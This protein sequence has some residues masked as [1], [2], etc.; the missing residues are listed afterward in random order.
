MK[1]TKF[2]SAGAGSGKTYSLTQE[3]A[4][5]ITEGECKAEQIILTTFTDAA[6]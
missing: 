6:A 3:I 4:Q 5:M 2:V 1:N